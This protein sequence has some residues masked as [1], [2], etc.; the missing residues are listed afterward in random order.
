M[1]PVAAHVSQERRCFPMTW[2]FRI[3]LYWRFICDVK[4]ADGM[5]DAGVGVV[6]NVYTISSRSQYERE[7]EDLVEYKI[8]EHDWKSKYDE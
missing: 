4:I 5:W 8:F 7:Q 2:T 6:N 1:V 3:S